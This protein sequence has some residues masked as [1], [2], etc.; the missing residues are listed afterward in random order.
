[1]GLIE[2]ILPFM[3]IK[4]LGYRLQGNGSLL[5]GKKYNFPTQFNFLQGVFKF[6][7]Y[8]I[9]Q[10]LY[11]LEAKTKHNTSYNDIDFCKK[12]SSFEFNLSLTFNF[13]SGVCS[14]IYLLRIYVSP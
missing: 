11:F 2:L 4:M 6:I 14:Q 13:F 9:A 10:L 12:C 5:G 7:F 8:N 1:M 3:I